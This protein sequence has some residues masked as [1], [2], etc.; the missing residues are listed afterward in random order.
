[1]N[2]TATGGYGYFINQESKASVWWAEGAYKV[3][4]DAPVPRK[5]QSRVSLSAA[6]NEYESFIIVVNP[7]SEMENFRISVADFTSSDGRRSPV[8]RLKSEGGIRQG[9]PPYG[10]L[11]LQRIFPGSAALYEKPLTL[12]ASENTPLWITVHV[13]SQTAA[14]QYTSEVTL[15]AANG[16]KTTVPVDLTVRNLNFLLF[17]PFVPD[18]E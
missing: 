17:L 6:K 7:E 4:K 3:L 14:G 9:L 12:K 5:S 10:L 13:P 15:T 18:G 11:W 8:T 2:Q 16:W 1:M